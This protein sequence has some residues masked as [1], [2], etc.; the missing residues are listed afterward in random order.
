MQAPLTTG[1]F[2]QQLAK[3]GLLSPD[4]TASVAREFKTQSIITDAQAA[5]FLVR[6][7]MDC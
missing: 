4:R 7:V 6:A 1:V 3:S 2:W 5:E